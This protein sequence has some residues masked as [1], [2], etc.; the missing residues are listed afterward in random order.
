MNPMKIFLSNLYTRSLNGG[1]ITSKV[2]ACGLN[3][4]DF[5]A[6]REKSHLVVRQN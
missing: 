3:L 5:F 2:R 4:Y 6:M 1:E